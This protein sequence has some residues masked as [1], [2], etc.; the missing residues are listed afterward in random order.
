MKKAIK[1]FCL[2]VLGIFSFLPII[3][4]SRVLWE[5]NKI[6]GNLDGNGSANH[7]SLSIEQMAQYQTLAGIILIVTAIYYII[8]ILRDKSIYLAWLWIVSFFIPGLSFISVPG[9]WFVLVN[10]EIKDQ[11]VKDV[12][13]KLILSN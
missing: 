12:D 6:I 10:R 5:F 13:D 1:I 8:Y 4:I 9:F 3:I 7:V 2:V 11:A